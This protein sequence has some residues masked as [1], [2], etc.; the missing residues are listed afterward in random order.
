MC[1][2]PCRERGVIDPD[3]GVLLLMSEQIEGKT[4][5]RYSIAEIKRI[6]LMILKYVSGVHSR[7]PVWLL[8]MHPL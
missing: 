4:Y 7:R 1:K 2:V 3:V 5:R 8:P 6:M